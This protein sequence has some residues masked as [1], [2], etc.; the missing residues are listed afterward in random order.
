MRDFLLEQLGAVTDEV[1]R[2][3]WDQRV[4][5]GPGAGA[6]FTLT[7][8]LGLIAGRSTPSGSPAS[9]MV[10]AHWDSR[11]VADRDPRPERRSLPVPGANDGASGVAV[12][13][14]L[15]RV[16]K[17]ERPAA[18]VALGFWDGEDFGE[19]YYG[20]RMFGRWLHRREM[21]RWRARTGVVVDMVGG[22]GLRCVTEAHSMELAPAA[23]IGL[24][25]AAAE[26]GVG[27]RFGGTRMRINDDHLYLSRGGIPTALLIG[28]DYPEW[29]TTDDL[30]DRCDPEALGT[31][32]RV[33]ER[34]IR[35]VRP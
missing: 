25:A 12:L 18:T 17:N 15:A 34:W 6:T 33:L 32:A 11:P 5:R 30:P 13:L 7:N 10:S 16:L 4:S 27:D 22:R 26:L 8:V 3:S 1:W 20:S 2:Q 29:H 14:E 21:D 24:H 23:W 31:V 9:V 19:Y 28:Y 35:G